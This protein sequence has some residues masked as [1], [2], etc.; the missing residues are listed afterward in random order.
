MHGPGMP[1]PRARPCLSVAVSGGLVGVLAVPDPARSAA[2]TGGPCPAPIALWLHGPVAA[3]RVHHGGHA[4][5]PAPARWS[6]PRL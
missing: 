6:P 4:G 5:P 1:E 2:A 3:A